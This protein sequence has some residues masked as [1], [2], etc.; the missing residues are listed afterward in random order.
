[1]A[2]KKRGPGR[3]PG[4]KN[5]TTKSGN[6][7]SRAEAAPKT[8][9]EQIEMMQLKRH[10]DQKVIDE[11][12]AITIIAIGIFFIFTIMLDTTGAF[13]AKIHD[14]CIG[15]FGF[16]AY[17]LPFYFIICGVLLLFQK[18]QHISGRTTC[19][20]IL[21]FLNFCILNSYR[22]IDS[23]RLRFGFGDILKYYLDGVAGDNGG[24]IGMELGSL[25]V[26]GF[27]KPGL[28]II[29][30]LLIVVSG[31]LVANTPLSKG[32]TELKNKHEARKLLKEM[33]AAEAR[34]VQQAVLE[35]SRANQPDIFGEN[36]VTATVP[37]ESVG[38]VAPKVRKPFFHPF[39]NKEKED[40]ERIERNKQNIIELSK[41]DAPIGKDAVVESDDNL[42]M[43]GVVKEAA[44][45][46]SS[47]TIEDVYLEPAY[48]EPQ[49]SYGLAGRQAG[50]TGYGLDGYGASYMEHSSSS[51]GRGNDSSIEVSPYEPVNVVHTKEPI[52]VAKPS[53]SFM[54]DSPWTSNTGLDI[55]EVPEVVPTPDPIDSL[56]VMETV[57]ATSVAAGVTEKAARRTSGVPKKEALEDI[58]TD[59]IADD[60]TS[61]FSG[62]SKDSGYKLPSIE[63]LK[64]P[65]GSAQKMTGS[66]LQRQAELLEKVLKDFKID[67]TILSVTQGSSV[68][69]YEVQPATGVKVSKITALEDDIAL[70]L[71]AKSLRIEAPIPGKAA[72]GIE[73]ENEKP[74]PVLIR[75]LIESDE[76]KN[77]ESK[78]T[79]VVG[80]DISGNNIVADLKGMPHML[81]AGATGSGKSVCINSIIT[82]ILYKAKPSEVKLIMVDPKVVELGNYNGIPHLLT[83]VVTDPRKAARALSEAVVEMNKR[84]EEF[85]KFGVRDLASFNELMVANQEPQNCK[86]QVVI[87]IDELA[88]LMMVAK[89]QVEE[90]ICRLAQ[91]A[92]AA[93][94]HLIIATQRP[95]V[96]VVTGLIKANVPSRI[97]FSVSSGIDSRTIL[98]MGGAEHL[99]GKGDMLFSPIGSN[100]PFRVQGPYISDAETARVIEAVKGQGTAS[101]NEELSNAIEGN[102][103]EK[104]AEME[105]ELTEEAIEFILQSKQASV[106]MLQRKFRIGY[107]RAAR[108]IDEIEALGIIGP[109]DGSRGRQ[110]LITADE[111]H[112]NFDEPNLLAEM[113]ANPIDER[114]AELSPKRYP[115]DDE[116]ESDEDDGIPE[117][118]SKYNE[119]IG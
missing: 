71:R 36:V 51:V 20:S 3:P 56:G 42:G 16:M 101:Y 28:I 78:L 73:V 19:F 100:K 48:E 109:S 80:K 9:Q 35:A 82:S 46:V 6:R 119:I 94:M 116:I 11:I 85:A 21:I 112:G 84:Y 38:V 25:L 14:I 65:K 117:E 44:D 115:I 74:S 52:D 31:L 111:Y 50:Q 63:L 114:L 70:N 37:T 103:K 10:A 90:S 106:S 1:M 97:A 107:N 66:Q 26:K 18:V 113:P 57:G 79:F 64:A 98:D 41:E 27:G 62:E 53:D 83:P 93:G 24:A 13:G 110:I 2:E 61:G 69:R 22:F 104:G 118:I 32:V 108:I 88:D 102:S 86:P 40:K 17:L 72:V 43:D 81:I 8:K 49:V 67:A 12:W 91:K 77:A 68:T 54:K 5:K 87:I 15:L 95:S 45:V 7:S 75:E 4:S 29:S 47:E 96:D 59:D 89:S 60:L 58:N 105:D 76:F 34:K 92:R 23:E 99:L 30:L 33:E 39:G 55:H